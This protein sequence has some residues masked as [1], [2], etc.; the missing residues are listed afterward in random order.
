[1]KLLLALLVLVHVTVIGAA[2]FSLS[3][4]EASSESREGF[5]EHAYKPNQKIYVGPASDI[6][7]KHLTGLAYQEANGEPILEITLDAAGAALNQAFTT[8]M[9]KKQ[10]AI[11]I[12]QRVVAA[13]LVMTP[14]REKFWT[15][16]LSKQEIDQLIASFSK[17]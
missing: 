5:T 10:I 13:P 3:I 1:M 12:N 15:S 14:S 4:H 7:A 2:E 6:T 16:G 17:R 8:T 11:L 9:Q